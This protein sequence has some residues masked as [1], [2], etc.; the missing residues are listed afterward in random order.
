MSSGITLYDYC[1]AN[2]RMDLLEQ[3]HPTKNG[4]LTPRMVTAGSTKKAWWLCDKGHEWQAT[5]LNRR[6]GTR[7]PGCSGKM[8]IPGV[9]DL[10]S[11]CPE[12]VSQWHPEL[13][14]ALTP[15][16]VSASSNK[17]VWW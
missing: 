5:I 14:N 12:L 17:N 2:D 9:N 7:C 3:W 16:M 4:D 11:A 1:T 6:H 13:N 10:A 8:V 15:Q